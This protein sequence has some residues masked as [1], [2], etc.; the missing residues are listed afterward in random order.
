MY[1]VSPRD[2]ER[3][4]LRILLLNSKGKTS[5]EDIRTV[6]GRVY[7][8]FSDAASSCFLDDDS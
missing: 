3:Y 5:F 6:D 1:I 2:F 7:E 4:C 8:K